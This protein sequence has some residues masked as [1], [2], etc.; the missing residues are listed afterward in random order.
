MLSPFLAD[1]GSGSIARAVVAAAGAPGRALV[2]ADVA[3]ARELAQKGF[4]VVLSAGS[5]RVRPRPDYVLVR[6]SADALPLQSRSVAV[7]VMQGRGVEL[8]GAA[9]DAALAAERIR[10]WLAPLAPEGRL[11][12]VDR[13]DGGLLGARSAVSREDLCAALLAARLTG[14]AQAAPRAGTVVTC[15]VYPPGT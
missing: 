14:I 9:E 4:R 13:I 6:A 12:L 10:S 15:G 3:I 1:L 7:V 5:R 11:V 2:L 8:R